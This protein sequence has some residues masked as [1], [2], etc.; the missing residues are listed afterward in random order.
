MTAMH[1]TTSQ[2]CAT[3]AEEK[4]HTVGMPAYRTPTAYL[5]KSSGCHKKKK[6]EM[7]PLIPC[8]ASWTGV[9]AQW[10]RQRGCRLCCNNKNINTVHNLYSALLGNLLAHGT[11]WEPRSAVCRSALLLPVALRKA[12]HDLCFVCGHNCTLSWANKTNT[13]WLHLWPRLQTAPCIYTQ[14]STA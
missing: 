12:F 8:H 11:V 3:A 10:L 14:M 1:M 7:H 9:A 2:H 4:P 6:K 13:L 5:I